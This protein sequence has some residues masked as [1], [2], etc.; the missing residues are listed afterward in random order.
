M[1]LSNHEPSKSARFLEASSRLF[2]DIGKADNE[3]GHV[4]THMVDNA[5]CPQPV[6]VVQVGMG[7]AI[8]ETATVA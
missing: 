1:P 4:P 5:E 3:P 7:M 2:G 8:D 6:A